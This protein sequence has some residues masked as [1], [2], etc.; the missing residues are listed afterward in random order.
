[1]VVQLALVLT[2]LWLWRCGHR[3][4]VTKSLLSQSGEQA[5]DHLIGDVA[6]VST[7]GGLWLVATYPG[8]LTPPA[9]LPGAVHGVPV[10]HLVVVYCSMMFA[11]T[12]LMASFCFLALTVVS[13][14]LNRCARA[15][16]CVRVTV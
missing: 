3:S 14:C 4:Y 1:M 7:V 2:P 12:F 9:P 8:L 10:E 5:R 15:Y 13:P 6:A 16:L 11:C